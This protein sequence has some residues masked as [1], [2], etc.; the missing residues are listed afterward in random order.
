M[1]LL[2]W[3]YFGKKCEKPTV[4]S[5]EFDSAIVLLNVGLIQDFTLNDKSKYQILKLFIAVINWYVWETGEE[6]ATKYILISTRHT[7]KPIII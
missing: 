3:K 7:S 1:K 2:S 4:S 6:W 5:G